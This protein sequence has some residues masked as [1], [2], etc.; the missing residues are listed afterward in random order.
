M[1]QAT[2]LV[3]LSEEKLARAAFTYLAEPGDPALG[4]LVQQRSELH[5]ALQSALASGR[6]ACVNVLIERLPAP[7]VSRKGSASGPGGH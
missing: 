4:A 1:S 2:S 3:K 5:A 7:V 6:P